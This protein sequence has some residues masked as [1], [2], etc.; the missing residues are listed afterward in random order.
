[1]GA[2][3]H[4]AGFGLL[5]LRERTQC[6][7]G[8]LEIHSAPGQGSR[9]I[10]SVPLIPVPSVEDQTPEQPATDCLKLGYALAQGIKGQRSG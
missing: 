5:S 3:C 1:M 4:I 8:N 7:G 6:M 10:L 9:F 2:Q